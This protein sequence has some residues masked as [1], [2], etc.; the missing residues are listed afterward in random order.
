[1]A[2][3]LGG[4]TIIQIVSIIASLASAGKSTADLVDWV[5][6]RRAEG[7]AESAPLPP[8]HEI[9][10]VGLIEESAGSAQAARE[11]IAAARES[12]AADFIGNTL[13]R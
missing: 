5:A 11:A 2:A 13:G 1:M 8:H 10:A 9:A 3:V 6:K 4:L 12:T 7:H